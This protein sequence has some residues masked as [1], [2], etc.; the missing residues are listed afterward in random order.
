MAVKE[1]PV[2]DLALKY[3]ATVSAKEFLEFVL[4]ED[5]S[6]K[7]LKMILSN[8]NTEYHRYCMLR[9]L[10]YAKEILEE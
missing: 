5:L 3:A 2:A 10:E 4:S 8:F 7:E 9:G 1:N 6:D